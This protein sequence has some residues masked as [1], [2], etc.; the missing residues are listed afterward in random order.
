MS[1]KRF[2]GA[3]H[4]AGSSSGSPF[5]AETLE[6]LCELLDAET[7][8]N[9]AVLACLAELKLLTAANNDA[10]ALAEILTSLQAVCDKLLA[11]AEQ[12][13][14]VIAALESL[15]EKLLA[16][17]DSL[18]ALCEKVEEGNADQLDCLEQIK[19]LLTCPPATLSGVLT[20]W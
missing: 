18:E 15:C 7:V 1:N 12:N 2:N 20:T 17:N 11:Q 9:E 6:K 19:E 16:T 4:K 8:N 10:V 3:A 14:V 5:A 13:D